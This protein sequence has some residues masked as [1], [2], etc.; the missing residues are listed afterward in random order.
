MKTHYHLIGIGGVGMGAIATLLLAKG[1]KV[2]G[3]DV[4][5][6]EYT[7]RLRSQG[8]S[9][10]IGHDARNIHCDTNI[11][12]YS[13]A[14][15][16]NN[17]ELTF[18]LEYNIPIRMRAQIL[19]G[20]MEDK[21]AITVAG[22]HGKTTT[23]S[24]VVSLLT[25]AD[26]NP[27]TAVGGIINGSGFGANLGQGEYF[28]AEVDESDGSFLY[29][30]PRF[31]VITNIDFEHVDYYGS[32]E[33]ICEAYERFIAKTD[34]KGCLIACGE[35]ETVKSLLNKSH[36]R[37][38]LYGLSSA[39]DCYALNI[40]TQGYSSSFDCY[41]KGECWGAVQLK[42]PGQHNILNA[43][44]AICLGWQL[45]IGFDKIQEGL[46]NFS[47]TKRRMQLKGIFNDVMVVDDY[48]HHP[49]EIKATLKAA[50]TFGRKRLVVV[51]QPHRYTRMKFLMDDFAKNLCDCDHLVLTDIY[52]AGELFIPG[53][54]TQV[55][56][57]KIKRQT[58]IPVIYL[59]KDEITP[60]LLKTVIAGD[61]ILTLGAGDITQICDQFV[62]RLDFQ[63]TEILEPSAKEGQP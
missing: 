44:A 46:K 33:K 17:P 14:I 41:I 30:Y 42:V 9:V 3:S 13:S 51:F 55:L 37:F 7:H 45:G 61:L 34:P 22:A 38:F 48:A 58:S 62:H 20:L 19:A 15:P 12:V 25:A 52:P 35:D 8:A 24:M 21:I 56:F 18:A 53:V 16:K 11:V 50:R 5:E 47:G 28:V 27:T 32:W 36:R 60:Y 31:S 26:L 6:S 29:F 1:F 54:T 63:T 43:L 4:K 49:T 2:S 23:T 59:K 10:L 39:C 40:Q 57:E